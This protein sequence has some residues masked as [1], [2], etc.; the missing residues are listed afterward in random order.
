VLIQTWRRT[1]LPAFFRMLPHS[2]ILF[3]PMRFQGSFAI[4]TTRHA[5]FVGWDY[6]YPRPANDGRRSEQRMKA[7]KAVSPVGL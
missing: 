4:T 2:S 5:N 1:L 7:P 3:A 6:R